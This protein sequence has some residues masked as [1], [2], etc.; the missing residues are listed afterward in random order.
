MPVL[1][2]KRHE[3]FSQAIAT[4][5]TMAQAA[6]AAGFSS[7]TARSIGSRLHK[8]VKI[9]RRIVDIKNE[10]V[11]KLERVVNPRNTQQ[12]Q[13]VHFVRQEIADRQYRLTVLQEFITVLRAHAVD[14]DGRPVTSIMREARECLK[15][16]AIEVGDWEDKQAHRIV[17]PGEDLS[18]RTPEELFAEQII[19]NE[20]IAKIEA[21]RDGN[22]PLE[23]AG[24][25]SE[26]EVV[27]DVEPA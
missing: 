3:L 19:L 6:E 20:A 13:A 25:C 24:S 14:E 22:K 16:A 21:L 15:H 2:N 9:Q 12:V 27:V 7:H 26:V 1:K 11:D 4:G 17:Q 18:N 23:I 8:D 10:I 5:S